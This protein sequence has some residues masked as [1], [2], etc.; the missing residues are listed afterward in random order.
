MAPA[1]SEATVVARCEHWD[2]EVGEGQVERLVDASSEAYSF[3]SAH[4]DSGHS[5]S[6]ATAAWCGSRAM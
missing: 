5:C 1:I 3:A 4:P 2:V 6:V